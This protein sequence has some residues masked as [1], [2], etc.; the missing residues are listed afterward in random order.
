MQRRHQHLAEPAADIAMLRLAE[1]EQRLVGT[2]IADG[3]HV[4]MEAAGVFEAERLLLVGLQGRKQ[5]LGIGNT[6]Q[7]GEV[8]GDEP[9]LVV[10]HQAAQAKGMVDENERDICVMHGGSPV[11]E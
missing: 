3:R 4:F 7:P 11:F 8:V 2:D 6:D 10:D 1:T 5:G 9:G